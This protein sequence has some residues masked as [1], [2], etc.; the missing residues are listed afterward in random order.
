[1]AYRATDKTI[2]KALLSRLQNGDTVI[3]A[4]LSFSTASYYLKKL[5]ARENPIRF[6]LLS[7]PSEIALHPSWKSTQEMFAHPEKYE[8]EAS[9]LARTLKSRCARGQSVWVLYKYSNPVNALLR[10]K[11]NREF[12]YKKEEWMPNPR[13]ASWFDS[14][15]LF[16]Y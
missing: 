9:A 16:R 1:M 4:D 2:M 7:F 6:E 15:L 14:I 3:A 8:E 13:E 10:E 5:N 12:L 11:L